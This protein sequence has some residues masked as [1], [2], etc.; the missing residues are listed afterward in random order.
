MISP[1]SED[2]RKIKEWGH[3]EEPFKAIQEYSQKKEELR[4]LNPEHKEMFVNYTNTRL[5]YIGNKDFEDYYKLAEKPIEEKAWMYLMIRKAWYIMPLGWDIMAKNASKIIDVGCGDGDTIQRIIEYVDNY[6]KI[7]EIKNKKLHLVGTDLNESR[8][9]NARKYVM[10]NNSN[11]TFEFQTGNF[12][13]TLEQDSFD[14]SLFTGVI[15]LLNDEQA[16]RFLKKISEITK[17]GMYIVDL[18]DKFPGGIPRQDLDKLINKYNFKIKNKHIVFSE[19]FH[20]N[21]LS[22]PLK[23]WPILCEQ[24]IW[25][26]KN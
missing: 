22:D 4:G 1:S 25:A 24:N 17:S 20:I 13:E 3:L 7:N 9:K 8:I 15:E 18:L 14:Y 23:I 19:P 5:G 16:E 26:E 12:L 21:R 11:I 2:F 6:W 10:S